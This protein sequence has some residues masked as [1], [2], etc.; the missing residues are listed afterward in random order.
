MSI[1]VLLAEDS[2]YQ[3]K[4]ITRMISSNE[5]IKVIDVARN[6]REAIQK[7]ARHNPD[8]L[9]LDLI[10]PEVDGLSVLEFLSEHYPIPTIVFTSLKL[11][12]LDDSV[13]A[14]LLGAFD[15]I[16]KPS[17]NW[18]KE[19]PKIKDK[20]IS[21]ILY[22]GKIK[23]TYEKRNILI[24]ES[25]DSQFKSEIGENL[26]V[27][28]KS[29]ELIP[30]EVS[31]I[32]TLEAKKPK[33]NAIVIGTSTGGPKTLKSILKKIPKDFPSPILI[34][35]HLDAFFMKQFAKSL[36]DICKIEIKIPVNGEKIQPG[37]VYLSP[38]G[39]HMQ[40]TLKSDNPSIKI[41]KGEPVNFCIPSVDVLFLSAAKVYKQHTMGILLTGLGSDG[42]V[43]LDAIKEEGGKT[44]AESEETCVVYGMPRAA[45]KRGAAKI[46]LPNY[47]IK[48]QMVKFARKFSLDFNS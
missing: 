17:G 45:V 3:R 31:K 6:G 2:A 5:E 37:K 28:Q 19:F 4:V 30:V 41:Y 47:K 24:K 8:V 22:A 44:I 34:V 7:I 9:L 23:K 1:R 43:G 15:F 12:S 32:S 20:L 29:T 21:S 39:K 13:Q 40:V 33:L 42:A 16:I 35:Q 36:N 38:G 14:L 27:K 48:D 26:K 18:E 11:E 10:M 25:I 46:V